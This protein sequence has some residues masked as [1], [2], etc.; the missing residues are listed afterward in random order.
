M[1]VSF[2]TFKTS[3]LY[4]TKIWHLLS[5]FPKCLQYLGQGQVEPPPRVCV[6]RELDQKQ[7]RGLDQAIRFSMQVFQA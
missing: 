7:R 2:T 5:R 4:Q 3:L 1:Y 6:G